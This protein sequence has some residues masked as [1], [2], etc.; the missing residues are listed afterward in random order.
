MRTITSVGSFANVAFIKTVPVLVRFNDGFLSS[1]P[2]NIRWAV[3][4][5]LRLFHPAETTDG[6]AFMESQWRRART[7]ALESPG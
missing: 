2:V 3:T 4:P 7:L 6:K 1:F 5:L